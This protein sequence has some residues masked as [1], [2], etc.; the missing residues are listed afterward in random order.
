MLC[1]TFPSPDNIVDAA[2]V[3]AART[4]GVARDQLETVNRKVVTA[5][6]ADTKLMRVIVARN[7][8][9]QLLCKG[10]AV[11]VLRQCRWLRTPQGD[12]DLAAHRASVE[13][14]VAAQQSGG[15][16]VLAVAVRDLDPGSAEV[17][18]TDV[19]ISLLGLLGF[20]D[21]PRPGA[22]AAMGAAEGLHVDVKV[23]AGD[24]LGRAAALVK[25]IGLDVPADAIVSAEALRSDAV[26]NVAER[27]RIFADVVPADK[28]A[29]R[30]ALAEQFRAAAHPSLPN[31]LA[32]VSGHAYGIRSDCTSCF[33]DD[34]SL[35]DEIEAHGRTWKSYQEPAESMLPGKP[36]RQLRT[37]P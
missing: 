25:Q 17:V 13:K 21:P 35:P 22:A 8:A 28:L 31:Y 30:Y 12:V 11:V 5:F 24:A 10:A 7:G 14:A 9:R 27:G 29:D 37:P 19:P 6:S 1:S 2:L 34:R 4:K 36:G 18:D 16:R 3:E 15:A 20:S 26:Q 33:V 32:L 23:V